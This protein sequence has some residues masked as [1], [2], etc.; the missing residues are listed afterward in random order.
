MRTLQK[1]LAKCTPEQVEQLVHLWGMSGDSATGPKARQ[2]R[3]L[4]YM[5]DTIAG[6]FVWE[7]L[8]ANERVLLYRLIVPANRNGI[9]RDD[10]QNKAG[11]STEAF[12]AALSTLK[13]HLLA[14]EEQVKMQG[15]QIAGYATSAAKGKKKDLPIEDVAMVY[16]FTEYTNLLYKVGREIFASTGDRSEMTSEKILAQ[17][18]QG[19]LYGIAQRYD[20]HWNNYGY[21]PVEELC[22]LLV[23]ELGQPE[24]ISY[25]LLE[26]ETGPRKLFKWLCE[27]GESVKMEEVRKYTSYDDATLLATLHALEDYILAFDTF[28]GQDRLLFLP[29]DKYS[30]LKKAAEQPEPEEVESGLQFLDEPPA[31]RPAESLVVYDLAIIIGAM[32]QQSIEPTQAGRVPKRLAAK[33]QPLLHG[34]PRI[35]Y[36]GEDDEYMEMLFHTAQ[37]LKLIQLSQTPL[38]DIKPHYEPGPEL[39]RWSNMSQVEQTKTL[40][41]LWPMSNYWL[42]IV[43]VNFRQWNPYAWNPRPA[44][45]LLLKYLQRCEPGRWYSFKSLL[46]TIWNED[47]FIMRTG[48]NPYGTRIEKQHKTTG[49]HIKWNQCDGETF[50]GL[51]SSTLYELGI[52]SLGYQQSSVPT[53]ADLVNPDAFLLTE[54]GAAALPPLGTKPAVPTASVLSDHADGYHALVVQP[55]FELLLLQPDMPT[56]YRLLPFAQVNQVEMVSRLTLTRASFA[57]GLEVGLR[58]EQIRQVLQEHS[59]KGIPQNIDYTLSD[60][61]KSFKDVKI[62]Q[63]ILLEVS[64]EEIANEMCASPK[65][66]AFGLRLL[67]PCAMAVNGEVNLQELRR[68][69]EKEGITVRI[70]GEIATPTKPRPVSTFGRLR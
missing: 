21:T 52:V 50:I 4:E 26:L 34:R 27:Q 15:D 44:R 45:L 17:L 19:E 42:D 67:G 23:K 18:T 3:L 48:P 57:R 51:L 14:Y 2:I 24:T 31:I 61:G 49:M 5:R 35:R 66:K 20:L 28:S 22:R 60:W 59:Q 68:T 53:S 7:H 1:E 11:L 58:P 10:L 64:S 6:R 30:S 56:L 12:D 65:L 38:R 29:S 41:Q 36:A 13:Q 33:F 32:Y 54:L 16:P 9:K 47:A 40:L 55:N 63:V 46:Q 70:S 39:E 25:M 43:G 37:E 69:L 8:S 62:T